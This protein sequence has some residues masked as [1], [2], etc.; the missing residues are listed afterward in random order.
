MKWKKIG[1]LFTSK[2]VW[3]GPSSYKN[4][5]YRAAVSQRLRNTTLWLQTDET[6]KKPVLDYKLR[7]DKVSGDWRLCPYVGPYAPPANCLGTHLAKPCRTKGCRIL[8][9]KLTFNFFEI[10]AT[11]T[12]PPSRTM[13]LDSSGWR[14]AVSKAL[15]II[16][17]S[18]AFLRH[19]NPLVFTSPRNSIVATLGT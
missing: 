11:L 18:L 16:H 4:R 2:F 12:L 19:F 8:L 15:C 3:T 17:A 6:Q 13:T 5:I 14:T 9:N 10:P 7:C 1:K